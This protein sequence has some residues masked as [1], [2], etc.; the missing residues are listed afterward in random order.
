MG[1]IPRTRIGWYGLVYNIIFCLVE[2]SLESHILVD[3][4]LPIGNSNRK[5]QRSRVYFL[6]IIIPPSPLITAVSTYR[7]LAAILPLSVP[8][9]SVIVVF[10]CFLLIV[11]G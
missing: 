7:V 3:G 1:N 8:S 6:A 2:I 5:F 9:P 11:M 4:K 10:A